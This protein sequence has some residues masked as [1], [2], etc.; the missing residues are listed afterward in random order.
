[1]IKDDRSSN[2]NEAARSALLDAATGSAAV[3]ALYNF[4]R[5]QGRKYS[6][7]FFC[8]RAGISS[9]GYL[10][11]VV[12][13]KRSLHAKYADLIGPAFFLGPDEATYLKLLILREAGEEVAEQ[14]DKV[15]KVLS[16]Q[17]LP[18]TERIAE[19][20]FAIEVFCALGLFNNR[21]R[22]DDLI[23]YFGKDRYA[24]VERALGQLIE[25]RMIAAEPDG[26]FK[27]LTSHIS[28]SGA[29]A[30][31]NFADLIKASLADAAK[32]VER[33]AP[34]REAAHLESG[35]VS[36]R[37]KDFEARL[38]ELRSQIA[39]L[40]AGLETPDA[41]AMVRVNVQIYPVD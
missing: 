4:Y 12:N 6:L 40:L 22:R 26:R 7:A 20:F 16:I 25:L 27:P 36:V 28:L 3:A 21:P 1:M 39:H 31:V 41:D 24:E 14:L 5:A 9:T 33:W 30:E 18:L 8:K 38:P 13:G 17:R 10:S 32:K 34:R 29:G 23:G 15:R 11:D 37:R 2:P 35:I 19:H